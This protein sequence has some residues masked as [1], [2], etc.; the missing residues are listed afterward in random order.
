MISMA[1]IDSKWKNI[2]PNAN[3]PV[4]RRVDAEHPLDFFIGYDQDG[5]MQLSLHARKLPDLPK[6]VQQVSVTAYQR[7]DG[8]YAICLTLENDQFREYFVSLCWDIIFNT[9]NVTN[10]S[11]GIE[12]AVRRFGMWL[13]FLADHASKKMSDASIKGL[14]GEL[15]VMKDICIPVYGVEHAINGWVGPLFADRDFEYEDNWFEVKTLSAEKDSVIIS[16]F[17]QLDTPQSGTLVIC[18]MDRTNADNAN[19]VS[20]NKAIDNIVELI[21]DEDVASMFRVRLNLTGYDAEDSRADDLF[22]MI[23]FEKYLVVEGF[24]RIQKST[25]PSAITKGKYTIDISEIQPWRQ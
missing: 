21:Q 1:K 2:V 17:D 16:S 8:K 6:S 15:L 7:K 22:S 12:T 24:P 23:G 3:Q 5:R 14:I 25:L 9:Y 11:N 13:I 4:A 19:A 20:L 10:N 18:R